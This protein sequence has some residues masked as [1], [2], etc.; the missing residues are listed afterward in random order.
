MPR[1]DEVTPDNSSVLGLIRKV[2][3]PPKGRKGKRLW[4]CVDCAGPCTAGGKRCRTC[5]YAR[6]VRAQMI[7]CANC[8][9]AAKRHGCNIREKNYCSQKCRIDSAKGNVNPNWRG[10][11]M[12]K[13]CK[14]CMK[15]FTRYGRVEKRAKYCSF[16]C[17]IE[18]LRIHASD[19]ERGRVGGRMREAR[20]RATRALLTQHTEQEWRDLL[21]LFN[22]QCAK[23]GASSRIE[24]DHIIPLCK[25][26]DDTIDN[27]QP[28]CCTCNRK[29]WARIE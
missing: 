19:R 17:R 25:G 15:P 26:G 2:L 11:P 9:K 5:H 28:L 29:K 22:G 20:L 13:K 6:I 1:G 4:V 18:G 7:A 12:E 8:G 10:G 3:P 21:A 24:R 27:I 14:R 16:E 23:C